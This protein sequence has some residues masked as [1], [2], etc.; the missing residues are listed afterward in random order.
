MNIARVIAALGLPFLLAGC[1]AILQ[2]MEEPEGRDDHP[3]LEVLNPL[4]VPADPALHEHSDEFRREIIQVTDRVHVAVGY[5]LANS[6]LIVGEGGNIIVD[7]TESPEV[8]R[9]LRAEF[10]RIS[11]A[12]LA[13]LIYTHNHGDHTFGAGGMVGSDSPE[14]LAHEDTE[15]LVRR[16]VGMLN[17]TLSA[18][19]ARMF[20]SSLNGPA[21]E[22]A[23]IGPEL[24]LS[25]SRDIQF[26]PPTRTVSDRLEVT[27]AGVRMV[28]VHAPGET[29][30]QIYVHL[31]DD[32]VLLPGDNFYRA[33]PNLYTIFAAAR[34]TAALRTGWPRWTPSLRS[35]PS[36]WCPRTPGRSAGPSRLPGC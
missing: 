21:F 6:I 36:T 22:N 10:D 27:I 20:G 18:R 1:D 31:P 23:G 26:V 11:P 14:V 28:L 13:A 29:D 25:P 9:S 19:A 5:A 12:P 3:A 8:A 35:V 16:V 33:F 32:K 24:K 30:D 7:A 17:P 4:E 15:A 2:Q 34:R